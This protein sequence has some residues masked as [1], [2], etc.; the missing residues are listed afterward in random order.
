MYIPIAFRVE[1][2]LKLTAFMQRHSF[3]TLVTDD[4]AAPFATHLPMLWRQGGGKHG[5]LVA[6]IA[7]A[8]P[9][10]QH[11]A[12]GR[13]AL[14]IFHGPHSYISP[15]WYK[16][17]VAVPTWNYAVVHAYGVP[18]VINEYERIDTLLRE[19]VSAFE[20]PF[21][22]PWPGQLPDD[23]WRKL[24]EGIVAFE[25][26]IA[27]LEGKFKLGQNRP[28]ED[29]RGVVE[30]LSSADDSDSRSLAEMMRR[31]CDVSGRAGDERASDG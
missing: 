31:E 9:Q 12:S 4:G 27:R 21:E 17:K 13:P 18:T 7:G 16:T 29:I 2:D 3:A 6:H 30:A 15:S 11:F 28:S 22:K 1:D 5:T 10:W 14:V 19:M 26:P 20:S 23:Y 8:N 24:I 25:I